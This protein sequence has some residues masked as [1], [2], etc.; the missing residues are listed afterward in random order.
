MN[1]NKIKKNQKIYFICYGTSTND[2]INSLNKNIKNTQKKSIFSSFFLKKDEKENKNEITK[3]ENDTFSKLT[4]IGIKECYMCQ[5]NNENYDIFKKI[6]NGKKIYT[7]LDYNAIESSMVLFYKFS[8]L[9]IYP[10]PFMSD[11]TNI[12]TIKTLDIFKKKFGKNNN[13]TNLKNYW[14]TKNINNQFLNIK[15]TFFKNSSSKDTSSK[16]TSSKINWEKIN[17]EKLS[18]LNSFNMYQFKKSLENICLDKY[19]KLTYYDVIGI[20]INNIEKIDSLII[21]CNPK[22]IKYMLELGYAKKIKYNKDKDI[23]ENTSLWEINID[24]HFVLNPHNKTM[25]KSIKY[26]S[27]KKIYPI[28]Y[29]CKP[30]KYNTNNTF[31]YKYNNYSFNLFNSLQPIPIQYLKKIAIHSLS[32]EK[33]DDAKKI[34]NETEKNKKNNTNKKENTILNKITFEELE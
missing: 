9:K 30:L 14:N 8:D 12:K 5:E 26:D 2:I 1:I 16:D 7:S 11:N 31:S 6:L 10:L 24:I 17:N 21:V 4:N 34:L 29:N 23:I 33:R 20:N 32:L 27:F 3:I 19:K 25:E 22:V 28:E 18:S 13:I 15:D